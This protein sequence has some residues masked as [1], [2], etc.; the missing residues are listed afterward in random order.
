M[1]AH[2]LARSL[3]VATFDRAICRIH[4]RCSS[5]YP[6]HGSSNHSDPSDTDEDVKCDLAPASAETLHSLCVDSTA[7]V[8][9]TVY[10]RRIQGMYVYDR[11]PL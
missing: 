10:H 2:G 6:Y 5:P 8:F 1:V 7:D 9:A 11:Y 4:P 3:P